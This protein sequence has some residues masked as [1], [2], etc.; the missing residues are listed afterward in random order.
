MEV[1]KIDIKQQMLAIRESVGS[2]YYQA[3]MPG[4]YDGIEHQ[5]TWITYTA[6]HY[7]VVTKSRPELDINGNLVR[8]KKNYLIPIDEFGLFS[9]LIDIS[10]YLLTKLID[11]R[12]KTER[13]RESVR[14][15]RFIWWKRLLKKF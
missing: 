1:V 13:Q 11:E 12:T 2:I 7:E 15:K 8:V 6:K 3:E 14:I 9:D 4:R 10:D 5:D